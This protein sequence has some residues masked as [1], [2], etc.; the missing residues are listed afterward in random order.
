MSKFCFVISDII[1]ILLVFIC[2]NQVYSL[3]NNIDDSVLIDARFTSLNYTLPE[4][5]SKPFDF[6][7]AKPGLIFVPIDGGIFICGW[8]SWFI[9]PQE[10]P[11]IAMEVSNDSILTII[12]NDSTFSY[13]LSTLMGNHSNTAFDTIAKLP[14]GS[15]GLRNAG[16]NQYWVWGKS[17]SLKWKIYKVSKRNVSVFFVS[18]NP[19]KSLT[20]Y[21]ND[22]ILFSAGE[23]LFLMKSKHNSILVS[24]TD[25]LIEGLCV[26]ENGNIFISSN[27]SIIE[28]N[29]NAKMTTIAKNVSGLLQ[30]YNKKIFVLSKIGNQVIELI[31]SNNK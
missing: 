19:I 16:K 28:I 4:T 8:N 12:Q 11:I 9:K 21:G 24:K 20:L 31:L 25:F 13:V 17:T 30:R 7:V 3:T 1:M 14:V 6:T 29:K 18:D 15:Y 27:N 5:Q 26:D 10:F 2:S 22:K 23:R